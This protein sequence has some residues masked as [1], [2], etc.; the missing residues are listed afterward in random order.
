MVVCLQ[1]VLEVMYRLLQLLYLLLKRFHALLDFRMFVAVLLSGHKPSSTENGILA[2]DS[3]DFKAALE[4]CW[5]L[6]KPESR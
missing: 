3:A 6:K 1:L 2:L 4:T 5:V